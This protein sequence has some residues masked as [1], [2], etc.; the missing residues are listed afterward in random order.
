MIQIYFVRHGETD[1]NHLGKHQGFSDIPLNETGLAQ[2][3]DVGE[4]LR[5]VHF[6]RAIVSDLV[7]ARVTGEEILKG[8]YIPTTFTEALRE[9][10][11][12]DW[13]SLTYSEINERWPGQIEAIY[14]DPSGKPIPNGETVEMVQERAYT[15]LLEELAHMEDGERL[16][17]VCHGGTIR[18]L[19]CALTGIPLNC[20][21]RLAQGNTAVS[22]M[23]FW[24]DQSPYNR[25]CILN[26]TSHTHVREGG[27]GED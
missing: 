21:W 18:T 17:V 24:G 9:I 6:D 1:W 14:E 25:I 12:G 11:F 27:Y 3:A 8:R 7:R 22:V 10:N 2:A 19:L 20:L 23:D 13:E 16:L 5:D 15:R 4:A 26:D